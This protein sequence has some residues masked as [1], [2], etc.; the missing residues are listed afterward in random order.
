VDGILEISRRP[1]LVEVMAVR[2]PSSERGP[3]EI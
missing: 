1:G 2:V 3:V